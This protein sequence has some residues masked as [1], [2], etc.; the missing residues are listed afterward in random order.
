MLCMRM[1]RPGKTGLAALALGAMAQVAGAQDMPPMLAPQAI[2][3]GETA[4]SGQN[5]AAEPAAPLQ[6]LPAARINQLVFP[7]ALYPDP[8]LSQVL[9]A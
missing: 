8:L 4:P 7:V 5:P 9:M 1:P 3:P 2:P 6:P